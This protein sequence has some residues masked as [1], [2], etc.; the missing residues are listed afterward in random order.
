MPR[1]KQAPTRV[2][3]IVSSTGI[4]PATRVEI[5]PADV[6]TEIRQA[7]AF[8]NR[9]HPLTADAPQLAHELDRFFTALHQG[10]R[11][12]A[13]QF[14]PRLRREVQVVMD[15]VNWA[16]IH[17]RCRVLRCGQCGYWM[18]TRDPRRQFCT[19]PACMQV[20]SRQ[21]TATSRQIDKVRRQI[22]R[23]RIAR[24]RVTG[25]RQKTPR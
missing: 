18:F 2:H 5:P 25:S 15:A 3:A 17:E 6:W 21:R 20:R 22:A 23:E 8:V 24:K 10:W 13:L 19:T 4:T 9:H 7:F 1:R 12:M 11:F 16:V 14:H